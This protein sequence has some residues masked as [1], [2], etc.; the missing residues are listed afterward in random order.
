MNATTAAKPSNNGTA[1][2][3][4]FNQQAT[5]TVK[6]N[7]EAGQKMFNTFAE[8][9][10][11]GWNANAFATPAVTMPAAFEKMAKVMNGMVEA[12]A[13]LVTEMSAIAVET[14]KNNAKT[15]ERT[16]EMMVAQM[17]AKSVKPMTETAR[18]IYDETVALN[19]KTVERMTKLNTEHGQRVAQIMDENMTCKTTGCCNN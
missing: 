12:N 10:T 11:K 5:E 6:A 8:T 7:M 14:M 16:G 9:F 13:K 2:A 15:M 3:Q 18:E 4:S 17:T 1:T 19:N